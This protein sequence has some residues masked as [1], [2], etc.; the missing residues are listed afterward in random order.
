VGL[1]DHDDDDDD[2]VNCVLG[3]LA[4]DKKRCQSVQISVPIE[5]GQ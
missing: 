2:D 3:V 5:A 1:D 4:C